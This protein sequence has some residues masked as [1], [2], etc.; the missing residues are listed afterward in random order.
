MT[1]AQFWDH[2]C[3]R[4]PEFRDENHQF[5]MTARGFRRTIE[6]AFDEGHGDG[7]KNGRAMESMERDRKEERDHRKQDA[8][9]KPSDP[10]DILRNKFGL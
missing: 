7:F 6:Q 10:F 1:K 2:V 9:Q 8:R 5:T 4:Y 3:K